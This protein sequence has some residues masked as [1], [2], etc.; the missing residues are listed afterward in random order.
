MP[1]LYL[2]ET[3]GALTSFQVCE[4][5]LTACAYIWGS[6]FNLIGG[7]EYKNNVENTKCH[8]LGQKYA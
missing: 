6:V 4:L 3:R 1:G 8:F 2:T 5:S 7:S